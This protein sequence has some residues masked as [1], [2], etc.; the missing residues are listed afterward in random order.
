MLLKF[1]PDIFSL[2]VTRYPRDY[3]LLRDSHWMCGPQDRAAQLMGP[4]EFTNPFTIYKST[5]HHN[6]HHQQT[7]TNTTRYQICIQD[8]D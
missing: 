3:V 2:T 8:E 7:T 1:I 4:S 6:N 5:N